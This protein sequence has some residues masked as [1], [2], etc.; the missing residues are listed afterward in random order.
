MFAVLFE[1]G[2][3]YKV[4]LGQFI[5]MKKLNLAP[6]ELLKTKALA[7]EDSKGSFFLGTPFV[8]GVEILVRIITHNRSKKV[9]VFKKNRRKGYRLTKGHR[10]DFTQVYIEALRSPS[11]ELLKK[12]LKKNQT[13]KNQQNKNQQ[14]LNLQNQ[15]SL[16]AK[17]LETKNLKELSKQ[18]GL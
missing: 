4:K 12:P 2:C 18:R 16:K 3:Q 1:S 9:L 15:A 11:G 17:N 13:K 14:N 8:K 7:F 5:R 10:Q 6:G